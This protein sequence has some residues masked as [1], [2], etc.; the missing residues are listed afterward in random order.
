MRRHLR[1]PT[2][3]MDIHPPRIRFSRVLQPEL[4]TELFDFGLDVLDVLGRVVA[5][6]YDAVL[7]AFILATGNLLPTL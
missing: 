1:R 6:A 2:L 7:A 5:F 3:Q 4:L